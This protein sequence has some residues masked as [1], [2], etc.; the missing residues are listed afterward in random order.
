MRRHIIYANVNDSD[1][2]VFDRN[3]IEEILSSSLSWDDFEPIALVEAGGSVVDDKGDFHIASRT[4]SAEQV[5][6]GEADNW[7]VNT[8]SFSN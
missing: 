5:Y 4:Y 2:L 1:H 6:A 8:I 7:G 3:L